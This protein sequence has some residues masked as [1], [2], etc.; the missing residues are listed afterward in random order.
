VGWEA[1]GYAQRN[2]HSV[3]SDYISESVYYYVK[4]LFF[5]QIEKK[6]SQGQINIPV[7]AV[8]LRLNWELFLPN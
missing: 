7:Q 4:T 8:V 2:Y 3:V 6:G 1:P 5:A